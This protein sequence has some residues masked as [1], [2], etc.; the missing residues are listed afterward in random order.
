MTSAG[1]TGNCSHVAARPPRSRTRISERSGKR[2]SNQ[3]ER[4]ARV[5]AANELGL[6]SSTMAERSRAGR[7]TF[8]V[9]GT[10]RA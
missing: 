8:S 6:L 2:S 1:E 3:V 10:L 7:E 4:R 9:D 5:R